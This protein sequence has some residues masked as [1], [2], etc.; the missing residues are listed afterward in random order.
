MILT[1]EPGLYIHEDD[2]LFPPEYRGIGVR[3]EDDFLIT[4]NGNINLSGGI[5]RH[6]DEVE[7]WVKKLS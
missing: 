7:K 5:P 3:I 6:P 4:K 2:E 1:I